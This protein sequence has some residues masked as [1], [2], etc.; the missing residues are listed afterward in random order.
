MARTWCIESVPTGTIFIDA[1]QTKFIVNGV[2]YTSSDLDDAAAD[3]I[4]ELVINAVER[5]DPRHKDCNDP[6]E[7]VQWMI[8]NHGLV[9]IHS[10]G[11]GPASSE[12][13]HIPP[14]PVSFV[15]NGVD[16][17]FTLENVRS[18]VLRNQ[19]KPDTL[20]RVESPKGDI[21]VDYVAAKN[22]PI[23]R[24]L[25]PKSILKSMDDQ[26]ARFIAIAKDPKFL[27]SCAAAAKDYLGVEV[28]DLVLYCRKYTDAINKEGLG[29]A[30][31]QAMSKQQR[32][33]LT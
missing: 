33:A 14:G 9:V 26:E 12:Y 20:I 27:A 24:R 16:G 6:I 23:I 4:E 21:I 5:G 13:V 3:F 18:Y 10:L 2:Y 7:M 28:T 22:I 17:L 1:A 8:D 29:M 15:I 19:V 32:T 31:H 11:K 25:F 30:I